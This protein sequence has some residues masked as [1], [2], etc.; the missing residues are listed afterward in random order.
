[1]NEGKGRGCPGGQA[2]FSIN[3]HFFSPL[4]MAQQCV[5]ELWRERKKAS[6]VRREIKKF[7]PR[8]KVALSRIV[9]F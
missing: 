4:P 2:F 7:R 9:H 6:I 8:K 1:M 3:L 5:C